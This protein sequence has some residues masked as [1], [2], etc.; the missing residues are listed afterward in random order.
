MWTAVFRKVRADIRT[1]RLQYGLIFVILVL[2]TMTLTVTAIVSRSA[3]EPWDRSFEEANGPHAWFISRQQDHGLEIIAAQPDVT[4]ATGLIPALDNHPLVFE[5]EQHD[6]FLYGLTERSTVARPLVADG[7]WVA[8]R[9]EVVLDFSFA[10]FYDIQ[11]GDT[12]EFLVEDGLYPLEVVGTAVSAHWFYYDET[13]KD[14]AAGLAYTTLESLREVE[15]DTELW[16]YGL[17]VRIKNPDDSRE[18]IDRVLSDPGVTVESSFDWQWLRELATLSNN[19]VV[20]FM[21]MFSLLGLVAVGF[22]IANAISGQ[23]LSQ[24]REIGILK[25]IGF[26]PSQ[27][28]LLFLAEHLV[29]GLGAG[30][31]GLLAGTLIGPTFAS[32]LA[33][34]LNTTPTDVYDPALLIGV[35]LAVAVSIT[36][37]TLIPAWN[38]SRVDTV[39]AVTVGYT[40]RRTNPSR[41]AQVASRLRLSPVVVLGVKDVFSHRFRTVFSIIG[42]MLTITILIFTVGADA[43][44]DDLAVNPMYY[45]GTPADMSIN[46]TFVSDTDVRGLLAEYSEIKTYYTHRMAFGWHEAHTE[47]PLIIRV[48]SDEYQSFDFRIAN[49]RMFERAGE[50]VVGYGIISN[51]DLEIGDEFTFVLE[52]QPFT[53]TVV[54]YYAEMTST[55]NVIMTS[56]ET[57]Q[58]QINATAEVHFYNLA[59]ADG[60]DREALKATLSAASGEQFDIFLTSTEPNSAIVQLRDT[61]RA[62][63]ML[64]VLIAG[65]NLLSTGLLSVRERIRDFGIQKTLGFTPRQIMLAVMTGACVLVLIAVMVG[66]PFGLMIYDGFMQNIGIETGSG[67]E[68][69]KMDW[70]GLLAILPVML[71]VAVASSVLPARRAAQVEVTEALRYE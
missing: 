55:G 9:G 20:L 35:L 46:R 71:L 45:Q 62:L 52:G 2:A 63:S 7:R 15:P 43:T 70:G 47:I 64:L 31:L 69:G 24:Y 61:V 66:I 33:D 4:E 48:L 12:L 1:N 8:N 10:R 58:Q 38:A 68:F 16:T 34:L 13:T 60:T 56:L 23:M 39:Q 49:G 51:Y 19:L 67:P 54:G 18:F 30:L 3:N 41:L 27:V 65:V 50:A 17:G 40:R 59:L 32:P 57:Y 14:V 44:M 36:L 11:V 42:L 22:I 26:K 25:A 37:F 29:I 53:V 28:V 5:G 6:M 21:G